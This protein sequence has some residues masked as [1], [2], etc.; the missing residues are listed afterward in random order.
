MVEHTKEGVVGRTPK[1]RVAK[2]ATELENAGVNVDVD[3]ENE[4]EFTVDLSKQGRDSEIVPELVRQV[5]N[6]NDVETDVSGDVMTVR[7]P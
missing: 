6:D 7:T 1:A 2:T 3:V 5:A 4:R